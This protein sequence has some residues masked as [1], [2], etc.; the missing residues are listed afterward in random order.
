[1]YRGGATGGL[2]GSQRT[3]RLGRWAPARGAGP[4]AAEAAGLRTCTAEVTREQITA[5]A[6]SGVDVGELAGRV[7]PGRRGR[8]Q[9]VLTREQAATLAARHGITLT[10]RPAPR[11]RP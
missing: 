9:L 5:L 6:R 4:V 8:V 3:S 10:E 7:P 1:M 11:A 2:V